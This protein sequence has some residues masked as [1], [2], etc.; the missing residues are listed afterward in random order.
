ME[1]GGPVLGGA[2]CRPAPGRGPL[3][4]PGPLELDGVLGCHRAAVSL[5]AAPCREFLSR[6]TPSQGDLVTGQSILDGA[7]RGARVC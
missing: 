4:R 5:S 6:S 2:V 7:V 3:P 1:A